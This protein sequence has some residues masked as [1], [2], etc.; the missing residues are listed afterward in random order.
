LRDSLKIEEYKR[1]QN[2][3]KYRN[4][5]KEETR[6]NTKDEN[7]GEGK[8]LSSST[9]KKSIKQEKLKGMKN[10]L[11]IQTHE[12][13]SMKKT[14]KGLEQKIQHEG[15]KRKNRKEE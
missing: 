3:G 13:G 5:G 9:W 8:C 4:K 7:L 10:H 6:Q 15:V 11:K 14:H 12:N 2:N 1:S